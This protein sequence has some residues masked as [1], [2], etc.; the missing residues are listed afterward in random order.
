MKNKDTEDL[1]LT[2]ASLEDLIKMKI[3]KELQ[4]EL[5]KA[6]QKPEK[7][8]YTDIAQVPGELIFSPAATYKLFNRISKTETFINGV[9]A[10]ALIGLQHAVRDKIQK[11]LLSAFA[12]DEA[13]VKFECAVG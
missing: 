5:D 3:E 2:G 9:Q 8:T 4:E 12:T 7:K 13:Y 1:L 10:E 11:G 6:R